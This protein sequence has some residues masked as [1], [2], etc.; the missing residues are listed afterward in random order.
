MTIGPT[1]TLYEFKLDPKVKVNRIRSLEDDIAMKVESIGGIRIIAPM[2]GRCLLYTSGYS[3][4]DLTG[5]DAQIVR[6]YK[7]LHVS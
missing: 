5:T 7:G 3:V 1:V 4:V 2:P 6:P